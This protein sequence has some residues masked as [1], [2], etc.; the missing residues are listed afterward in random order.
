MTKVCAFT[1]FSLPPG[2]VTCSGAKF[3]IDFSEGLTAEGIKVVSPSGKHAIQDYI[4][5]F[6]E[7]CDIYKILDRLSLAEHS[8]EV[9]ADAIQ[10]FRPDMFKPGQYG[11]FSNLPKNIHEV[12]K[13]YADSVAFFN[14]LPVDIRKDYHYSVD[15]FFADFDNFVKKYAAPSAA[16]SAAP[17]VAESTQEVKSNE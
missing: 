1:R 16:S 5:S 10:Q 2:A 13:F 7:D 4:D 14:N 17:S 15:E 3:Q 12:S 9:V 8:P 11:D 6:K